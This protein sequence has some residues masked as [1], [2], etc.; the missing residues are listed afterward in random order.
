V[1]ERESTRDALVS[2]SA[3]S[4]AALPP[5]ASLGTG[6]I[7]RRAQLLHARPDLEILEIRDNVDTR[8]RKLDER[9]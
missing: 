7:R 1:P 6:S 4:F 8:L 5:G 3:A 9:Q 2:R